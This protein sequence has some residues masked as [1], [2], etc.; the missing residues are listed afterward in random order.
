MI[1]HKQKFSEKIKKEILHHKGFVY[2]SV[3]ALLVLL[4]VYV[5]ITVFFDK[6]EPETIAIAISKSPHSLPFFIAQKNGYFEE[7]GVDVTLK[8]F[9]G[10][11]RCF[12]SMVAGEVDLATASE[13]VMVFNSFQ[14]ND[15]GTLVGFSYSDNS[16]KLLADASKVE[17]IE[18]IK[19]KKVGVTNGTASHF[20]LE[21]FLRLND[22]DIGDVSVVN[23]PPEDMARA[24]QVG[25]VDA[26]SVWEPYAFETS[27]L[28]GDEVNVF[29]EENAYR[30]AFNLIS[31]E[32]YSKE[33]ELDIIKILEALDRANTYISTHKTAAQAV[34]IE[35][36]G[37][38]ENFVQSIWGEYIY[39]LFLDEQLVDTMRNQ[40]VWALN[41]KLVISKPTPDYT[42][43]VYPKY[44]QLLKPSAVLLK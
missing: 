28:L 37:Q 18:D 33:H 3:V 32:L 13:S 12:Q 29:S 43:F 11:F 41:N 17:T 40:A 8:E 6:K 15:F 1:L 42:T 25:S 22:M 30:L 31:F 24:L 38:D 9:A 36:L 21:A 39:T 23:L 35:E 44:L 16:V 7:L 4:I 19:G 26:I 20:F 14:R 10:G 34:L 2:L 27:I 5:G